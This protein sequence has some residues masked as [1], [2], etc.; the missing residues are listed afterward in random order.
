[1]AATTSSSMAMPP[2]RARRRR[3]TTSLAVSPRNRAM[4]R[5]TSVTMATARTRAGA[6]EGRKGDTEGEAGWAGEPWDDGR[7]GLMAAVARVAG[8][9]VQQEGNTV[10]LRLLQR[11]FTLIELLVVIAI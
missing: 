7:D 11:A 4:G 3:R 6:C 9:M 8:P 1:M 5:P 10:M 2:G